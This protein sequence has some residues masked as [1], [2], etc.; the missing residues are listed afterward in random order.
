MCRFER[1]TARR[2]RS[3]VPATFFRTRRC[4]RIRATRLSCALTSGPLG[5]LAGLLPNVLAL[6]PD[7]LA[8]VRLGLADLADV[9]SHLTDELLVDPADRDPVRGGHLE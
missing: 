9:R 8:L 4:R 2:G 3:A 7:A 1:N 5:R 6:V